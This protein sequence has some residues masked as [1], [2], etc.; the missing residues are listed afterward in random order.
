MK[1]TAGR[2]VAA[3]FGASLRLLRQDRGLSQEALAEAA[4]LDRTTPSLYER[5]RRQPTLGAVFVL[6]RALEV[7]PV[8]LVRMTLTR[9]QRDQ[10]DRCTG[11]FL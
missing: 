11:S 4:N 2:S 6:S 9:L 3:A 7:D 5:G 8:I 1:S 10:T